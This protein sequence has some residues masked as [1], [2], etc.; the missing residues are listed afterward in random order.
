VAEPTI[1]VWAENGD[2]HGKVCPDARLREEDGQT[3]TN[4]D[5]PRGQA[6]W[7]V[8]IRY[9][10]LEQLASQLKELT[11]GGKKIRRLA[12]HAHAL[13]G[14]VFVDGDNQEP[15]Q[16]GIL[17]NLGKYQAS[18]GQIR[19]CLSDD[20]VVIFMGCEAAQEAEGDLFL[21]GV[22]RALPGRKVVGI[23]TIGYA[24]GE[25]Y[26]TRVGDSCTEPGMRD[27]DAMSPGRS[28]GDD[29]VAQREG[30]WAPLWN[31]LQRLPWASEYSLHAVV[32]RNGA[33][34]Q[35]RPDRPVAKNKR[36]EIKEQTSPSETE[37]WQKMNLLGKRLMM[38]K[39]M[40]P[41]IGP[42]AP[43]ELTREE[44]LVY[45]ILPSGPTDTPM[46]MDSIASETGLSLDRARAGVRDLVRKM[47]AIFTKRGETPGYV[48]F[49]IWG[50]GINPYVTGYKRRG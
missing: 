36:E 38:Q 6:G 21:S 40:R 34:I 47:G 32:A 7:E 46:D 27:T 37:Q 14:K 26:Q 2:I 49:M 19:D 35:Q 41:P 16:P 18:L 45:A 4:W 12:I 31:D 9:T 25:K 22:S 30:K 50:D 29:I 8:G 1:T 48:K 42:P 11:K 43:V 44:L 10:N 3:V 15:L 20:A 39:S 5:S 13:P 33:I 28:L 23:E 17:Q 24:S